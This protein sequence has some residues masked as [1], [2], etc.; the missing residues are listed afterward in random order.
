[1]EA[2]GAMKQKF[3]LLTLFSAFM[4]FS[5]TSQAVTYADD[6]PVAQKLSGTPIR[7]CRA[8]DRLKVPLIT[9]GAD[10]TT[11]YAN[12]SDTRTQG[13]S[14]FKNLGLNLE[15]KREDDF[16]KQVQSYMRCDSPFLRATVG[17]AGL[18]TDVTEQDSRTKM[19]AIYQHSWS[20]GGDALVVKSGI[21]KPADL[22]GKTIA[23]QKAGPHVDYLMTILKDAGLSP[24]DV[25]IK[26]TN[27]LVG[28]DGSTP[29]ASLREDKGIDAA[30]V[31]IP[32]ALALT[33]DGAVGTGSENSVKGAKILL[34]TKSANRVIADLYFVRSDFLKDNR[35]KVEAFVQ[36]LIQAEE[37]TR[38]I[39]SSKTS[40]YNG[41]MKSSAKI[42][43]DS[44]YAQADAQ[45]MW[46]DAETVGWAG[47]VKFFTDENYPRR[48]ERLVSDVQTSLTSLGH[49][50]SIKSIA[51]AHWNFD[52]FKGGV[53]TFAPEAARFNQ[54]VVT[55]AITKQQAQG[56]IDDN[57]LFEF[58]INFKP[59]Q[60]SFPVE[61]YKQQFDRVI[62]LAA[63][64]SGAVITVEGHSD[65]LEYL[66]S[67]KEGKSQV[68]L[69]MMVQSARNL[70]VSRA[71][72]VRDSIITLG[73][74][75]SIAM[76]PSQFVVMGLGFQSPKSGLCGGDPCPP[77]SE[78]E[79]LSNMRVVFRIVNVEAEANAFKPL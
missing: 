77:N 58:E 33:S 7:D 63:T 54:S 78:Q 6:T 46:A 18:V 23:L 64:Y 25:T 71:Q 39:I 65:P 75:G 9:W 27:D 57:T 29:S 30:M 43:L 47:N 34:S 32:D 12:G 55:Q 24:N 8:D 67:K 50:K 76:D 48:F 62:D 15:L 73:K 79:W 60:D 49:I 19:V 31:I 56:T 36:G 16:S 52:Q 44:E 45:A 41:L 66:R 1:M 70:S 38:K 61:L 4:C 3:F 14:I 26:W 5:Q 11:I 42:L 13:G 40:E 17:M 51:Q 28:F 10:I 53:K 35:A 69:N 2:I 21:A 20:S 59:N 72:S 74:E 22:K 37:K 68:V